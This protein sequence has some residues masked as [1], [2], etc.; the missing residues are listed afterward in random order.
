MYNQ[1]SSPKDTMGELVLIKKTITYN[2]Q[3]CLLKLNLV[4]LPIKR[5]VLWETNLK[6][7]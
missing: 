6:G 4:I 1:K 7:Q 3:H 2:C 5:P